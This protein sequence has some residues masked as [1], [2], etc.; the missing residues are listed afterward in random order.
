[1]TGRRH[2]VW[3]SG[4]TGWQEEFDEIGSR[5]GPLKADQ[6]IS[7]PSGKLCLVRNAH[8]VGR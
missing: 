8:H 5:L 7:A 3:Y 2:R 6:Q 1:M 4:D